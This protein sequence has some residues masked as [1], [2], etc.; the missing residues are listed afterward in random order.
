[1][2]VLARI[3][4]RLLA[5]LAGLVVLSLRPRQS[6]AAEDLFL[7]RQLSLY[8]ERGVKPRSVDAADTRWR[9]RLNRL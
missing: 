3:V 7:R 9:C 6:V 8:Q 2:I 4:P 1:V 5:D